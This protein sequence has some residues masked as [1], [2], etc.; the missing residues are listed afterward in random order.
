MTRTFEFEDDGRTFACSVE[1]TRGP[2]ADSWWWFVVSGK[3]KHRYAPFRTASA[4][5]EQS[6]RARIVRYYDNLLLRRSQPAT[7]Y[8]QRGAG[9]PVTPPPPEMAESTVTVPSRPR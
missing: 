7:T 8:W 5:T 6:V 1:E 9:R 4:D 2:H 3:D